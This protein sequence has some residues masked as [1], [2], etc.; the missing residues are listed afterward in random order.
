M[1]DTGVGLSWHS[2][3]GGSP[4][5]GYTQLHAGT[6][7][8]PPSNLTM[9]GVNQ[10]SS[11]SLVNGQMSHSIQLQ[12]TFQSQSHSQ[13]QYSNMEYSGVQQQQ[14][15][16]S[17]DQLQSF[18]QNSGNYQFNI[19]YVDNSDPHSMYQ[20]YYYG[21]YQYSD[22]YCNLGENF[23][24]PN[25]LNLAMRSTTPYGDET[26]DDL[27]PEEVRWFY[28]VEADKK[29]TPFIGYDSLRI[30]WK[31]RDLLQDVRSE[32]SGSPAGKQKWCGNLSP[33]DKQ[34]GAQ[35]DVDRI[36][37]RGGL[38]EVDVKQHKCE[39]IYWQGEHHTLLV[40]GTL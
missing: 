22:S 21:D 29:W 27:G 25:Q 8:H 32:E 34:E 6:A 13:I 3:A 40:T 2:M 9:L 15:Y 16:H 33:K 31:Y 26:V 23:L 4:M 30:E 19:D 38:Y 20:D 37:V 1:A 17:F 10:Y 7:Q 35:Q 24:D 14:Q 11:Q 12:Q 28:K 39:S 5:Q 18:P 36:V